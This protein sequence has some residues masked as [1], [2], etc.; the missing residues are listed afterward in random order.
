MNKSGIPMWVM[1]LSITVVV[2]MGILAVGRGIT[3][4]VVSQ[5]CCFLPHCAAEN[6]CDAARPGTTTNYLTMF[7]GVT[8]ILVSIL[9]FLTL[10]RHR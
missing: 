7:V 10:R 8:F 5:S 6:L 3:G 2:V 9:T 4:L 1:Y